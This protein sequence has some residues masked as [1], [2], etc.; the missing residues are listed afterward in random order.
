M[1]NREQLVAAF[2]AWTVAGDWPMAD[3]LVRQGALSDPRR[4]VLEALLPPSTWR[5]TAGPR[6]RAWRP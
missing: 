5:C 2:G 6:K 4:A 3:L 1:V